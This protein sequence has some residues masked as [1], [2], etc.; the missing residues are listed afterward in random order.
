MPKKASERFVLRLNKS[1]GEVDIRIAYIH[2][3]KETLTIDG[4]LIDL[5]WMPHIDTISDPDVLKV[6]YR[7]CRKAIKE[8]LK[9]DN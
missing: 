1:F 7:D 4:K 5:M 6:L 8:H 9:N 3:D 2:D